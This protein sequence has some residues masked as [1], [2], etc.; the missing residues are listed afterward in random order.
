[1]LNTENPQKDEWVKIIQD[2]GPDENSILIG[3]SLGGVAILRYLEKARQK[4]SQS[5]LVA[6]P[7]RE[8]GKEFE[9]IENF[10]EPDFAWDKIKTNCGRFI[11]FNQTNDP[12]V[13]LLHGQDLAK[14]VGGEL[15]IVEGQN[16]FDTIDFNLLEKYIFV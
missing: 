15:V 5:I 4:V 14:Y 7:I 10:L 3:H 16:H 8:L 1:M 2:F 12:D 9:A 6:T 13:P 11:I